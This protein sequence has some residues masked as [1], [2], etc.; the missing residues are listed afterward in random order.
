MKF[1]ENGVGALRLPEGKSDFV[2]FDDQIPG[3]GVRLRA[4]GG[5]SYLFQYKIRGTSRRIVIGRVGVISVGKARD[6]A[7]EYHL[8]VR[9]GRD[10]AAEKEMRREA[11]QQTFLAVAEP[12]LKRQK[13]KM[14]PR[15]FIQVERHL[16]K[17][18]QPLH[19]LCPLCL[20][21]RCPH[22]R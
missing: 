17:E 18:A 5:R 15:S 9:Q 12:Y 21:P 10:P 22:R 2:F 14:R 7:A 11:S 6:L 19:R 16:L 1:T 8:A 3:F 20:H 4:A 13:E